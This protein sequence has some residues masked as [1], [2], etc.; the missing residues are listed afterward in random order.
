MATTWPGYAGRL[1]GACPWSDPAWNADTARRAEG[2]R[3]SA[4]RLA[5]SL[6]P[7]APGAP[8]SICSAPD[9]AQLGYV[10]GRNVTFE[11]RFA[12][13]RYDRMPALAAELVQARVD[14]VFTMGTRAA[15]IVAEAVRTTPLV[16]YSCD[17]F[18]HVKRLARPSGNLTGVT[19]MTTEISPKRQELLKRA[20]PG[21][22]RVAFLH[23]PEAAPN[24]FK[25]TQAAAPGLGVT[26][27]AHE[28]GAEDLHQELTTA[29]NDTP[30]RCSCIPTSF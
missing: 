1:G 25:M 2:H 19:C 30:K 24:A 28:V 20:L 27:K 11:Q 4:H 13:C 23:D 26:L 8:T 14:V 17:P 7:R 21:V 3:R 9:S 16:V 18:E 29:A 12:D 22:S 5:R 10:E 15:R 6:R